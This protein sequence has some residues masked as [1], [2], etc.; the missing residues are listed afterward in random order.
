LVTRRVQTTLKTNYSVICVSLYIVESQQILA[1]KSNKTPHAHL[2]TVNGDFLRK[3]KNFEMEKCTERKN[4]PSP[5]GSSVDR[6]SPSI[7]WWILQLESTRKPELCFCFMM[8]NLY[9][10]VWCH[11]SQNYSEH[12]QHLNGAVTLTVKGTHISFP[13][14]SL[15]DLV[16]V[17]K[18]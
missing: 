16:K 1:T 13:F 14:R 5:T 10:G 2:S 18:L 7:T 12:Q 4:H 15:M 17:R 3:R 8:I 6:L 11:E 9:R